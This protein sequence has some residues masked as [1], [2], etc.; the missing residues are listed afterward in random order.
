[1]PFVLTATTGVEALAVTVPVGATVF[2]AVAV[3]ALGATVAL[4]TG[5]AVPL[6]L[7][8]L[9]GVDAPLV[10]AGFGV[11]VA[12]DPP[13]AARTAAAAPAAIPRKN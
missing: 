5:T 12:F 1:V 11:S 3:G 8:A 9:A 6:V 4:P 7:A 2:A 10:G 13:Q